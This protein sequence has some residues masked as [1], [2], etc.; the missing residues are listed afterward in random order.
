MSIPYSSRGLLGDFVPYNR[1]SVPYFVKDSISVVPS[2]PFTITRSTTEG[3]WELTI[4]G[5]LGR[6]VVFKN[7]SATTIDTITLSSI[8]FTFDIRT[9]QLKFYEN[10][11]ITAIHEGQ[12]INF[13]LNYQQDAEGN[14]IGIQD[15]NVTFAVS[16]LDADISATID[17]NF[18]SGSIVYWGILPL[19]T[20][21]ASN[22]VG[23]TG[24][25]EITFEVKYLNPDTYNVTV[26]PFGS[27]ILFSV[28]DSSGAQVDGQ[29][30]SNP[31]TNESFQGFNM[32]FTENVGVGNAFDPATTTSFTI[33]SSSVTATSINKTDL[34]SGG[35][36]Q[37]STIT[38][39]FSS[40]TE[41][42]PPQDP[43]LV[44]SVTTGFTPI[45]ILN[46][47]KAVVT[48]F[49]STENTFSEPK[50]EQTFNYDVGDTYLQFLPLGASYSPN[51]NRV[52]VSPSVE[53]IKG[54]HWHDIV[55]FT[56]DIEYD[57]SIVDY[58]P[59]NLG[60]LYGYSLV[61]NENYGGQQTLDRKIRVVGQRVSGGY[62]GRV[63][64]LVGLAFIMKSNVTWNT[65][66]AT[67]RIT[68]VNSG[69]FPFFDDATTTL[70]NTTSTW[71]GISDFSATTNTIQIT[72]TPNYPVGATQDWG[73]SINGGT[74]VD[75]AIGTTSVTGLTIP[76]GAS[77]EVFQPISGD[78]I[79]K[80]AGASF[81]TSLDTNTFELTVDTEGVLF[82]YTAN[83][84]YT[85]PN[86]GTTSIEHTYT[87]ST[88]P[89]VFDVR[90][91]NLLGFVY[92]LEIN[93][94]T[95]VINNSVDLNYP[96]DSDGTILGGQTI[97]GFGINY[98]TSFTYDVTFTS[99][100]FATG[101]TLF[102]D[103]VAYNGLANKLTLVSGGVTTT[104]NTLEWDSV[105]DII[106]SNFGFNDEFFAQRT[107]PKL[108]DRII[109]GVLYDSVNDRY[110][111]LYEHT[112]TMDVGQGQVDV[113]LTHYNTDP[114][115]NIISFIVEVNSCAD[116]FWQLLST[117]DLQFELQSEYIAYSSATTSFYNPSDATTVGGTAPYDNI[118]N[119]TETN[120]GTAKAGKFQFMILNFE[121]LQSWSSGDYPIG[122]M[123]VVN[124]SDTSTLWC[125]NKTF[126][127]SAIQSQT[128][129][130]NGVE[131][132]TIN[133]SG[134]GMSIV[135]SGLWLSL[136][137]TSWGYQIN[138]G[139]T[140]DVGSSGTTSV[141]FATPLS[142]G[143]VITI[144]QPINGAN[145]TATFQVPLIENA[146]PTYFGHLERAV[147]IDFN[148]D[149]TKV[150]TANFNTDEVEQYDLDVAYKIDTATNQSTPTTSF[151]TSLTA[152]RQVRFNHDGTVLYVWG[153]IGT[154]GNSG[155]VIQIP[156]TGS[157]YD[158][159]SRGTE[160]ILITDADTDNNV[161]DGEY[162][163]KSD[164]TEYV[165]AE[166]HNGPNSHKFFTYEVQNPFST[167]SL[168]ATSPNM[169]DLYDA[170]DLALGIGVRPV[171]LV[172]GIAMNSTGTK[173]IFSAYRTTSS[174]RHVLFVCELTTP[175]ILDTNITIVEHKVVGNES[176][177]SM[178]ALWLKKDDNS[179][180]I[181]SSRTTSESAQVQY[182]LEARDFPDS[183]GVW[184]AQ[185]TNDTQW[186]DSND[187]S[188]MSHNISNFVR[189]AGINGSITYLLQTNAYGY[190][191]INAT[192]S[193]NIYSYAVVFK[194]SGQLMSDSDQVVDNN[195]IITLRTSGGGSNNYY[196]V[197]VE[198]GGVP[199][200]GRSSNVS[201]FEDKHVISTTPYSN[202][203][204]VVMLTWD[205][206]F[207][208]WTCYLNGVNVAQYDYGGTTPFSGYMNSTNF[209]R[210]TNTQSRFFI[211]RAEVF[212][213]TLTSAE[214]LAYYNY[215][216]TV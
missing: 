183:S 7:L 215:L 172:D 120:S 138:G 110:S 79:I 162:A 30:A 28:F 182:D 65:C 169:R 124:F 19:I 180:L 197:G 26:Q 134:T 113:N 212:A 184:K 48:S 81:T 15:I 54:R 77:I 46:N 16:G 127:A 139:S 22:F 105:N 106:P 121:T 36:T 131:S 12:T 214:A 196:N 171:S 170:Y 104:N 62:A 203:W 93:D 69:S 151:L 74:R 23:G 142:D 159:T 47:R 91:P 84:I 155:R 109:A 166:S 107:H 102:H 70:P 153:H 76:N 132:F 201:N 202:D 80:L 1:L 90:V 58:D 112:F 168:V 5:T 192:S 63:T 60:N 50:F 10:Q 72:K 13:N 200:I 157:A 147:G 165:Y 64:S 61:V 135:A 181:V 209:I 199:V 211:E 41:K 85:N 96:T 146:Y 95:N 71:N 195:K 190:G 115:T 149:G 204:N 53:T 100:D 133:D 175:Y 210:D 8:P 161:F 89:F 51:F 158:I 24:D 73:Y 9:T 122:N 111:P 163:R 167:K 44:R 116:N 187:I 57:S 42:Y 185:E 31:P 56:F 11:Q 156:L 3:G 164:G 59:T 2:L 126:P 37:A 150:F 75:V 39:S 88:D 49:N 130:W 103:E 216:L 94:G 52:V 4:E 108:T 45:P 34:L 160:V 119:L 86:T 66:F 174:G 189:T 99:L 92:N 191:V 186:R 33:T 97:T 154:G 128:F 141:T 21:S 136:N 178:D 176:Q 140:I 82:P 206:T 123:R 101:S 83:F 143:D 152:L 144:V 98:L 137:G 55:N 35:I 38:Q 145:L 40:L 43:V 177:P 18:D 25:Y 205:S 179:T 148:N 6:D 29:I 125:G 173:A 68:C 193:I 207:N 117:Y 20:L 198:A 14:N 78:S 17:Y 129:T 87:T 194:P 27:S 67:P 188:S 208:L 114:I 213:H 118:L 32:I